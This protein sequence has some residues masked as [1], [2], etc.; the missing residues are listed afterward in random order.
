MSTFD[1]YMSKTKLFFS[2]FYRPVV[3]AAGG[4]T[5]KVEIFDY[6]TSSSWEESKTHYSKEESIK[7]SKPMDGTFFVE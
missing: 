7:K 5:D 3:L 1:K 2:S 4:Q 6:T